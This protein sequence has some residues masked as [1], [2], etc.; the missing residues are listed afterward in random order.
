MQKYESF[1]H[2]YLD[3]SALVKRYC[4]EVGSTWISA[5]TNPVTGNTIILSEITMAETA[6]VFAAKHRASRGITRRERDDALALFQHHCAIDYDLVPV[7]RATIDLAVNLTQSH[8]LR[9]YDA[10]QLATALLANQALLR[11]SLNPL[12]FV[13][14]DRDLLAA[15]KP[16]AWQS[17]IPISTLDIGQNARILPA[18]S[19]HARR[20][21]QLFLEHAS[22]SKLMRDP[23][24][25][26]ARW[27]ANSGEGG[28]T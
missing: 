9:G 25:P 18:R 26:S 24:P 11:L 12:T 16:S 17:K 15:A 28:D 22:L 6:A 5:L 20:G 14:A 27:R 2:F 10:V 4:P 3:T 23:P 21:S 13:A 19:P 7:T 1:L 8:R